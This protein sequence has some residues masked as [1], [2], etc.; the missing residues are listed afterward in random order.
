MIRYTTNERIDSQSIHHL[1]LHICKLSEQIA[2]HELAFHNV[3]NAEEQQA[4]REALQDCLEHLQNAA[5]CIN[6][7]TDLPGVS[8]VCNREM[9]VASRQ[10]RIEE[11]KQKLIAAGVSEQTLKDIAANDAEERRV[12]EKRVWRVGESK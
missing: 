4:I 12:Q 3:E 8:A 1:Q 9:K 11:L 2:E 6:D 7:I 10:R 5:D